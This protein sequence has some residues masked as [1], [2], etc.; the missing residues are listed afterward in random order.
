MPVGRSFIYRR[1][2]TGP[3]TVPCGTPADTFDQSEHDP[4]TTTRCQRSDKMSRNHSLCYS[5]VLLLL[6]SGHSFYSNYL[7]SA[8]PL[9]V[10]V[11]NN[12]TTTR[13]SLVTFLLKGQPLDS[14]QINVRLSI[15]LTLCRAQFT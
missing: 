7:N 14:H 4:L 11:Y 3:K 1:N 2:K 10:Y 13:S 6:F 9:T 5:A 8:Q 12:F 15:R